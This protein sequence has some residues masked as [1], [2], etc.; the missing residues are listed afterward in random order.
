MR[1]PNQ[2][3]GSVKSVSGTLGNGSTG[4]AASQDVQFLPFVALPEAFWRCYW[5]C[6]SYTEGNRMNCFASCLPYN[7]VFH[8]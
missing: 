6:L 4:I 5:S 1:L 2:S 7:L 8:P 3:L